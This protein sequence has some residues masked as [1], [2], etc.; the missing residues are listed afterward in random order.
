MNNTIAICDITSFLHCVR[1][2]CSSLPP[3]KPRGEIARSRKVD[4]FLP[5]LFCEGKGAAFDGVLALLVKTE[6]GDVTCFDQRAIERLP[7]LERSGRDGFAT[8]KSVFGKKSKGNILRAL[9]GED[10]YAAK[11]GGIVADASQNAIGGKVRLF[12]VYKEIS[13]YPFG[14]R[15]MIQ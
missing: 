2:T 4:H 8:F 7:I 15:Q 12:V 6:D 11:I 14:K 5:A 10:Q 13:F 9:F 3:L 1:H